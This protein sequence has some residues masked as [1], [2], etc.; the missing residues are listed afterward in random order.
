MDKQKVN[1]FDC[2]GALAI[3]H[4]VL[5]KRIRKI[6]GSVSSVL[7]LPLNVMLQLIEKVK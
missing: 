7:G 6:E 4:P 5:L 3:E 2:C 1:I